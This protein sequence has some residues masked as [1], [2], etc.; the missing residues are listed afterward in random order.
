LKSKI[1]LTGLVLLLTV[2]LL[3]S[4]SGCTKKT[5]TTQSTVTQ[6]TTTTTTT[7]ANAPVYGG[8]LTCMTDW[9]NTDPAGFD[10]DLSP[11]VWSTS[12]WDAPFLSWL[13]GGDIDTYGPRGTNVFAF[14]SAEYI[15]P[16]YL[17]GNDLVTSWSVTMNPI[18]ITLNLRTGVNWS[19]NSTIGMAARPFSSADVVYSLTRGFAAPVIG[20]TYAFVT[21]VTA[22]NSSTVNINCNTFNANWAY[23]IGYGYMPG[24]ITCPESGNSTVG[25]GSEDWR[26]QSSD[27]PFIISNYVLGSS[28]T[29]T[30]NPNYWGQTTINGQS[31]K[32]PF[33][34]TLVY[35]II[36]DDSTL[37][38]ALETGKVD[39]NPSQPLSD[40]DQLTKGNSSL[41][42]EKFLT[43]NAEVLKLNRLY[44]QYLENQSVRR[45]LMIATDLN[46]INNLEWPGSTEPGYPIAQGNPAYSSIGQLPAST[47]QLFTYNAASAKQML[48][49]A[50]YP[51]GFSLAIT[52]S[53]S[54][55]TDT[56]LAQ[57]LVSEWAKVGVT[58]TINSV[59]P[60]A[61]QTLDS[62]HNFD[63]IMESY[64]C[65]NPLVPEDQ[66]DTVAGVVTGY[67]YAPTENFKA[68]FD[69]MLLD[70]DAATLTADEKALALAMLD[71]AGEIPFGDQV[72]LNVYQPWIKNYYNETDTGY[73]NRV[74]MEAELW[75][76]PH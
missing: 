76:A 41:I 74:P 25:A 3:P 46:T 71:D 39:W 65:N 20:N 72:G 50:G 35:P 66:V 15:P 40:S 30:A 69:K 43:G 54:S 4:L 13:L 19:A 31:Y 75:I 58:L 17:G 67:P 47:A 44:N 38:A 16:Q 56:D 10:A 59:D 60:T 57:L 34:S 24:M 63:C 21:S 5:T 68:M 18:V 7:N 73:H 45:A 61:K 37:V 42:Q 62:A 55:S 70:T 49:A 29:Y 26:N 33:V 64:S 32:L 8:T 12:V 27:G 23:L 11:A 2:S 28:V 52:I 22:P 53:S 48:T 14:Q 1:I 9:G 6:S 51:S 36:P